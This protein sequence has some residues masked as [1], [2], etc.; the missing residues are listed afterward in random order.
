M[1]EPPKPVWQE[2]A[3]KIHA[4]CVAKSL[5][6]SDGETNDIEITPLDSINEKG[7]TTLNGICTGLIPMLSRPDVPLDI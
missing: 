7:C 6:C 4:K 3:F 1:F 5:K 2:M